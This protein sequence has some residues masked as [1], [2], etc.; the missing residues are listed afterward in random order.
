M[1]ALT[2]LP[3]R[4]LEGEV[5]E[6]G[7]F[8]E[9]NPFK[10][11]K[12]RWVDVP[13]G[14]TLA[15][16][17]AAAAATLP[18]AYRPHVELWIDE[19]R[20]DRAHWRTVRPKP[21]HTVYAR[22]R[23]HGGKGGK[24]ILRAFL[25]IVIVVAATYFLGPQA[26]IW[27]SIGLSGL[28]AAIASAVV[29]A[30]VTTVG[31]LAINALIPAPGLTGDQAKPKPTITGSSN[32]FA[33]FAQVPR[34][35][36][37]LRVYPLL[38][39]YPYT[40]VVG[41]K[42]YLRMLLLVGWGPIKISDIR[43][44]ETPI[45]D[46][47][48]VEIEVTEGGP[49]GWGGNVPI[50]LYNRKVSETPLQ[51]T[52]S[53]A[54]GAS[55][56][57]TTAVNAIEIGV[58]ITFPFGL[59]HIDKNGNHQ[60]KSVSFSIQ[61][62]VHGS[63]AWQ[64]ATLEHS[65]QD[66][67]TSVSGSTL[68]ATAASVDAVRVTGRFKVPS[69]QYDVRVTRTTADS[70]NT[71]SSSQTLDGSY[72]TTLRSF[73]TD[74][75]VVQEGVCLIALR[76]QASDQ[77]SGTPQTVNCL[78][79]AYVPVLSGGVWTYTITRNPAWAYVDVLRRR[80][81]Q[82]FI[83][84]NRIDSAGSISA[85]AADCA[86]TAPNAAE[87]RWTYDGV[88]Q[89]VTVYDGLREIAACGRA[90]YTVRDGKYGVVQDKSQAT[91]V[92]VI[93]PKNSWGYSAT[94]TYLQQPH[95]LRVQFQN[96]ELDYKNDELI[97][98]G[99]GYDATTATLF[100]V[101]PLKG[102]TSK[103][104]AYREARY[105][106]AVSILRPEEHT[107]SMDIE[108]LRCTRGDRVELAYDVMAVG[109]TWGR[110]T[111]LVTSGANTIGF[112]VDEDCEFEIGLSYQVRT[113]NAAGTITTRT[114]TMSGGPGVTRS[115]TLPTPE[116]TAGGAAVG[117]LFI[118]GET[119]IETAPM[120]VK[121]I[122]PGDELS[123]Q[124]TMTNYD[125]AIYTADTGTIPPFTSYIGTSVATTPP[126]N[127]LVV[128]R[129]D[130]SSYDYQN[131]V[132]RIAVDIY[133]PSGRIVP[134][135]NEVQYRL[136][137]D[138]MW[139]QV[140]LLHAMGETTVYIS[141]ALVM[142]LAYQVRVRTKGENGLYSA[143]VQPADITVHGTTLLPGEPADATLL[144]DYLSVII[145]WTDP[146]ELDFDHTQILASTTNDITTATVIGTSTNGLFVHDSLTPGVVWFYW[147]EA[148]DKTGN[149]SAALAAGSASADST[150]LGDNLV[151]DPNF[152]GGTGGDFGGNWTPV[153]GGVGGGSG[154]LVDR[155][156]IRAL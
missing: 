9:E 76:L 128:L 23:P 152:N 95:A 104:L 3:P 86:A 101:L 93:T 21:G 125:E 118:F 151:L 2:V 130:M 96:A 138:T 78:A 60:N 37:K 134:A 87:P 144:G 129:S 19:Q 33:P 92:Q 102:C 73:S 15:E 79:E 45:A 61:F 68:T 141:D 10:T 153:A 131:Q 77:L 59:I 148:I 7:L 40:E 147:L 127:P 8:V 74:Q 111:G 85:W 105:H 47:D 132:P 119:G 116:A 1:N 126:A 122:Q 120:I 5:V 65:Y 43:L 42:Q 71:S 133:C 155:F 142:G 24:N 4:P 146:Q 48:N 62:C 30:V 143:W 51:I 46:Y 69:G 136:N 94:R 149:V 58:D 63:G 98:Y 14:A 18:P 56:L 54:T 135:G 90:A 67:N 121:K 106:M 139:T 29:I 38:A 35:Y 124:I 108:G 89:N 72:W 99:A 81:G 115:L 117:D 112:T 145:H 123:V 91:P 110:I 88:L 64:G 100:E 53:Q 34:M 83:A 109:K 11:G 6:G 114:V 137:T 107:V 36:G 26:G 49:G 156:D 55:A 52:L 80:G 57:Q 75:P 140:G 22:V 70:V 20:M 13:A 84:D 27:A 154:T 150:A 16:H 113:R 32:Q 28:G 66:S 39:G 12:L 103:T 25:M 82:T 97:V 44:G 50:T 41:N 17:Y 31:M